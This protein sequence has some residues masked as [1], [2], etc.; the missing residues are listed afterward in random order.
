MN[1]IEIIKFYTDE[2]QFHKD[3]LRELE[4]ILGEMLNTGNLPTD[5][6]VGATPCN[7]VKSTIDRIKEDMDND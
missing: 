1:Y 4:D 5:Y 6:S 2:I 3:S 7:W